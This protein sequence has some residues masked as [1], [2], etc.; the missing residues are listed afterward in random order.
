MCFTLILKKKVKYSE[1][2]MSNS[3]LNGIFRRQEGIEI[4][5]KYATYN[6][7]VHVHMIYFE[8]LTGFCKGIAKEVDLY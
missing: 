1:I 3:N 4:E 6:S 5:Y 7:Q 8:C 2:C